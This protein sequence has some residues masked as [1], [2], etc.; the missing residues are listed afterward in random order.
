M[1]AYIEV[2]ALDT[3][4]RLFD[5]ISN[6]AHFERQGIVHAQPFHQT[7]DLRATLQAHQIILK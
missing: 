2:R 5:D 6:H 1:F 7:A 4:L 3:M